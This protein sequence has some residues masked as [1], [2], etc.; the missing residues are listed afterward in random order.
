[1]IPDFDTWLQGL[2]TAELDEFVIRVLPE[3]NRAARA[4]QVA[5]RTRSQPRP[6]G[7]HGTGCPP[8]CCG[9]GVR[10]WR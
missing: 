8:S 6:A 9:A 10:Q 1:V 4:E 3:M 2:S 5:R 7:A